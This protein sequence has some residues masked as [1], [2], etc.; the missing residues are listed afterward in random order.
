MKSLEIAIAGLLIVGGTSLL[1][2]VKQAT[3]SS[4]WIWSDNYEV[5]L[6]MQVRILIESMVCY[7][8]CDMLKLTTA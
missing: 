1:S 3:F 8:K 5:V 7:L 4:S 6:S 2:E